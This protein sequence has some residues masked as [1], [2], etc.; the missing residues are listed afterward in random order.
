MIVRTLTTITAAAD[1][2][3]P[4]RVLRGKRSHLAAHVV[5]QRIRK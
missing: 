2:M 1:G 5:V 3:A 4:R